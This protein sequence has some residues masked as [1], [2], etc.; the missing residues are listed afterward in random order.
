MDK[1][2]ALKHALEGKHIRRTTWDSGR[3]LYWNGDKFIDI[4]SHIDERYG[5]YKI[6]SSPE[7]DWE[8]LINKVKTE[9]AIE[10]F[11]KGMR[12]RSYNGTQYSKN[13]NSTPRFSI[14]EILGKWEVLD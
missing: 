5:E 1:V 8:I 4:K 11:E 10:A 2:Q 14:P 7:F 9:E 12:I 3:Y 13:L 6:S